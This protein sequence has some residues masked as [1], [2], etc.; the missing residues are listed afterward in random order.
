MEYDR[1]LTGTYIKAADCLRHKPA[2]CN[3]NTWKACA[4][5]SEYRKHR[6]AGMKVVDMIGECER[7]KSTKFCSYR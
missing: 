4:R 3:A 1:D 6:K 2:Q 7:A 5:D